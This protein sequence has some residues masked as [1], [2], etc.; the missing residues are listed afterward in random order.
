MINVAYKPAFSKNKKLKGD[1]CSACETDLP[2][3]YYSGFFS[4]KEK[5]KYFFYSSSGTKEHSLE[6]RAGNGSSWRWLNLN[7]SSLR[8]NRSLRGLAVLNLPSLGPA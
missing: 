5:S 7:S 4:G 8:Y 2:F 6:Q 1:Y 3:T